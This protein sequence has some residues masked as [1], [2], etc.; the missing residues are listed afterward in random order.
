MLRCLR[1]ACVVDVDSSVTNSAG[2]SKLFF[3]DP[4]SRTNYSVLLE[5]TGFNPSASVKPHKVDAVLKLLTNRECGAG[6][7]FLDP[8]SHR[9]LHS[10]AVPR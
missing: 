8:H 2:L 10:S 1:F 3:L 5:P 7:A 6:D 4:T 9:R